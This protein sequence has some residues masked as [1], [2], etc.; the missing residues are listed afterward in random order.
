MDFDTVLQK[1]A[2]G[3]AWGTECNAI[4]IHLDVMCVVEGTDGSSLGQ[5]SVHTHQA[6]YAA[7]RS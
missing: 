4:D 7:A 2:Q 3:K 1:T 6:H 5:V